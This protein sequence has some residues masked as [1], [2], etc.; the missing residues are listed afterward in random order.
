M[1]SD[2]HIS[3]ANNSMREEILKNF[4]SGKGI[5]S[6]N[7]S[8][9]NKVVARFSNMLIEQS[10]REYYISQHGIY[11]D[12][13]ATHKDG[14]KEIIGTYT[15]TG[16]SSNVKG[17]RGGGEMKITKHYQTTIYTDADLSLTNLT[18]DADKGRLIISGVLARDSDAWNTTYE[19]ISYILAGICGVCFLVCLLA[20][21]I[22]F[23]KLGMSAHNPA[24][25]SKMIHGIIWTGIGTAGLGAITVI[26]SACYVF[27]S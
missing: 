18:I 9:I 15:V 2:E 1:A 25:R 3:W 22:M 12:F 27:L 19:S 6:E 8:G 21:I 17:G 20:F 10:M 11:A 13:S 14:Y 23:T 4:F 16:T 7:E 26:F 24:E 5:I